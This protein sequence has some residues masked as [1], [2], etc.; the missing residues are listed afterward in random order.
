MKHGRRAWGEGERLGEYGDVEARQACVV[1]WSA[2]GY[3][4]IWRMMRGQTDADDESEGRVTAARRMGG[5]ACGK[6]VFGW[7]GLG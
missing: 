3:A 4:R 1:V 2:W 5:G 6:A 7:V